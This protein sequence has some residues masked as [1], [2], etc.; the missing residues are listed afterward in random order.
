MISII[1]RTGGRI[2][3]FPFPVL[4][5]ALANNARRTCVHVVPLLLHAH[6]VCTLYAP[7]AAVLSDACHHAVHVVTTL[8]E[9]HSSFC[10]FL[11]R[12]L[13]VSFVVLWC[14]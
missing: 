9:Q 12:F 4:S 1:M 7:H 14:F 2:F 13:C 8:G 11:C 10:V 5:V 3:R 6:I